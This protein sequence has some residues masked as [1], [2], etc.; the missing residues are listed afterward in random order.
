MGILPKMFPRS[1]DERRV[2]VE[3][4]LIQQEAQIG[5]QLF[6]PIPKGHR[7]QFFCLDR[8]TWVWYEEWVDK[9]GQHQ[10]ITT[11]YEMHPSGVLK[12]HNGG[13]NYYRLSFEETRNLYRS[14]QLYQKRVGTKYQRALAAV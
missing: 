9:N 1:E 12:T 6:G 5:G 10:S 4:S 8:Y 3:R 7:R 11:H 13:V 14:V 2:R